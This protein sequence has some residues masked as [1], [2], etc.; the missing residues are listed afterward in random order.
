MFPKSPMTRHKQNA[1]FVSPLLQFAITV[2][3]LVLAA[4]TLAGAQS[5]RVLHSFSLTEG[6]S[7][8]GLI[9][10]SAGNLFGTTADSTCCGSV[11]ELSPASPAW[12]FTKIYQFQGIPDGSNLSGG[13]LVMDK[14]GNL[15]GT[16]YGGGQGGCALDEG[17]GTFFELS[18]TSTG[19]WQETLSMNGTFGGSWNPSGGLISDANGR[20]FGVAITAGG[21]ASEG[22]WLYGCGGVFEATQSSSGWTISKVY[23]PPLYA[24]D[25][26]HVGL[27]TLG[28][29][30]AL[31]AAAGGGTNGLGCLLSL[32]QNADG[33]W[34]EHIL[35]NFR[36]GT[37]GSL[38]GY[39]PIPGL[40]PDG[41]GAF[42]GTTA[43]GGKANRGTAFKLARN[44][45]GQWTVTVIFN[46]GT[47]GKGPYGT[48]VFD[49]HGNLYG[50]AHGGDTA[51]GTQGCG[52]LFKL[53]PSSTGT[54]TGQI[55]HRFSGTDGDTPDNLIV[56]GKGHIF[57]ITLGGGANASGAVFELTP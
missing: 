15:Y 18:P 43:L 14:A 54:W 13:P 25:A 5:Y 41:H 44:S 26:A 35:H 51:C 47:M 3:A 38:G 34:T 32:R 28:S 57:G 6:Q 53:T 20:L 45:S 55:V 39:S 21:S 56:D 16:T 4:T 19:T 24:T 29:D 2:A 8:N 40:T 10:D 30:G 46:F 11:F 36:G 37:D 7:P 27:L 12:K 23:N 31:Y 42:Y 52:I 9:V 50:T 1:S 49:T 22:C 17:C 48:L 33:T